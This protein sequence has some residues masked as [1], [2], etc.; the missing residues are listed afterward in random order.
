MIN[1]RYNARV[2]KV[3]DGDTIDCIVDL[4]FYITANIR[5]RLLGVD[6]PETNSKDPALKSIAINAKDFVSKQL[7]NKSVVVEVTKTDKY[8]RWLAKVFESDTQPSINE[9]LITLG[10]A[11]AY[12]GDSKQE[13]WTS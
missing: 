12:F 9:Q 10:Y 3:V 6:T 11:K 13:L 8:G 2:V 1:Y 5:F 4:G 7:L